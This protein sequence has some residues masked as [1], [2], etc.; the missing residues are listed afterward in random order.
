MHAAFWLASK[1]KSGRKIN[2]QVH[3]TAWAASVTQIIPIIICEHRGSVGFIKG[4]GK[5]G[6]VALGGCG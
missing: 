4:L 3:G 1:L 6:D 2:W 5:V